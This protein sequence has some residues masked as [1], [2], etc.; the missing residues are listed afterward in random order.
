MRLNQYDELMRIKEIRLQPMDIASPQGDWKMDIL[1]LSLHEKSGK[2]Y[3]GMSETLSVQEA[4]QRGIVTT[5]Q[6]QQ[7][8][9]FHATIA[10]QWHTS[11]PVVETAVVEA[12]GVEEII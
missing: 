7:A 8:Y 1:W 6:M 11:F 2:W 4:I 5:E 10:D 12:V 3:D 9:T